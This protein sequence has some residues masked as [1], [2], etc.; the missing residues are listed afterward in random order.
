M[1][2]CGKCREELP[3]PGDVIELEPDRLEALIHEAKL[4]L[5]VDF[6]SPSCAPCQ[7][8]HPILDRLARRRAGELMV[9]RLN[10]DQH[11]GISAAFGIKAVPTFLVLVKGNERGRSSG[12]LSE[13]DFSLWVAQLV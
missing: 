9:V 13:T 10:T 3:K 2:V 4:P 8:M 12:A 1:V 11:P 7:V 6:Y 5:L